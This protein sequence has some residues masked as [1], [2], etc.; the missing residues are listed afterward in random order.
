MRHY[1]IKTWLTRGTYPRLFLPVV[2]IIVVVSLVRYNLMFTTELQEAVEHQQAQVQVT[3]HYLLPLLVRASAN[4]T[5]AELQ[6]MLE[7][8][9]RFNPEIQSLQ[10]IQREQPLHASA[11]G[12]AR[13][14]VPSWFTEL[15]ALKPLG[16]DFAQQLPDGSH[17][18]LVVVVGTAQALEQV[19]RTIGTQ[20]R[21]SAL[22]IF[23]ILF[24]LA[25]L[26]RANA[27]MLNRLNHATERF[28]AGALNTRMVEE[29]TLEV[30]AVAQ[31]FNGMA[32]QVQHLVKS[33]Q[34]TQTDLEEQLHFTRQLINAL[35]LPVFVR[36]NDG[37]CLGVNRAWEEF[38]S[39]PADAMVGARLSSDFVALPHEREGRQLRPLSR[40]D[41]EVLVKAGAY[42]LREMAYF[43]APFT[44]MDGSEGGTIGA[45]VD[46]TDRKIAQEALQEE[47]ERAEVT[48]SSIADGVITTNLHGY[49]ESLNEAAQFLTGYA[50]H[51]A[52]GHP[53]NAVFQLDPQSKA[54]PHGLTVAKLHL[55]TSPIQAIN[56]L[57]LH[58]AGERYAI[59][60]TAAPIR[61]S[62]GTAMGCVLVFRDV[63]E[64]RDL[65]QK[66]SWQARHDALTG[67]N[68]RDALAQR[69]THAMHQA[70]QESS[71]LAVCLLDLNNFQEINDRYG[72][73]V[74]D[75]LLKEVALRLQGF[76]ADPGDAAR[77][78]GDEFVV[79]LRGMQSTA[80]IQH[81]LLELLEQL[82]QPYAIDDL[83]LGSCASAGVVV[84]PMDDASP[85]TLLRHADQAMYQAKQTGRGMHIFDTQQDQEVHTRYNRLAVM[86]QA[87]HQ[88]EF[89]LY[90]QPKVNLRTGAVVGAEALLRWQHP[91]QGLLAPGE[92]LPLMEH[93][94]LIVETGEWVLHQ[95]LAQLQTWVRQGLRWVV[96]VNI[97]ARHFHRV[98]F[99]DRLRGLLAC[100]PQAPAHLLELEIL[101]SAIL[102]D[103]PHMRQVMQGCQALGVC[104]A[105]DDFGTGFSSLSYLKRLPAETIKIDRMFVDG[106]L[107]DAEDITLVSA[108]VAL[109]KAFERSV[110][111]EGVET[112]AQASKLLAL[113]CELGQGY[114]IA[115]PMPPEAIVGWAAA[116]GKTFTAP[117]NA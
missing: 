18:Q 1:S 73:R 22:N 49:I 56:Q 87:L 31:T 69:L 94:D 85:D 81:Q 66:I 10:W 36:D 107:D 78:G 97:A 15:A 76:V 47:K 82:A 23:A 64:T 26:L 110:I 60:F 6:A 77:L 28:R 68:N 46:I 32:A 117:A 106:I 4:G 83:L 103:I 55:C 25:V 91:E 63:T 9:L 71:L 115:R 114:G 61:K 16:G 35:P 112:S 93:S 105:L 39:T 89:R 29:G 14:Q 38:F 72:N 13:S 7:K 45:L 95:A 44:L 80:E 109:A 116:Y 90:Y 50:E 59:E 3:G 24:V 33:L 17:V 104:F 5:Q 98:D 101:E 53:L 88:S 21:I 37:T 86:S 8:E 58:H 34:T 67:L 40:K 99:V 41:N 30:R 42:D 100:Y 113:G 62:D 96:S 108:I 79:L 27:R 43:K 74:G 19:W 92:F 48:L 102:Q 52:L 65:Q 11:S 2:G 20:M 12:L 70:R 51:Q 57:L 84:Y 54:L 75:R 111:A